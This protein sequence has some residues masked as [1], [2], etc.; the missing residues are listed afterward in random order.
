MIEVAVTDQFLVSARSEL[1]GG[2]DNHVGVKK[3]SGWPSKLIEKH[4]TNCSFVGHQY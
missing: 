3:W 1:A 2:V 4:F